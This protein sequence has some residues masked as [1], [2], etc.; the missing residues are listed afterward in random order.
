MSD[1]KQVDAIPLVMT[2]N[3]DGHGPFFW[4]LAVAVNVSPDENYPSTRVIVSNS[5]GSISMT[6]QQSAKLRALLETAELSALAG[7]P[8][9]A[10]EQGK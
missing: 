10:K 1:F 4:V 9:L 7:C 5:N 3:A 6:V 2:F 8:A